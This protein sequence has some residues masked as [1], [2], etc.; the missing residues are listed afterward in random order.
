MIAKCKDGDFWDNFFSDYEIV[1]FKVFFDNVFLPYTITTHL[2]FDYQLSLW[3]STT[4]LVNK[5]RCNKNIELLGCM[6]NCEWK[7]IY[8]F[9]KEAEKLFNQKWFFG[10]M[11][12]EQIIQRL[13]NR[14]KGTFVVRTSSEPG[15][16]AISLNKG[17]N[18]FMHILLYY[19]KQKQCFEINDHGKIINTLECN[20]NDQDFSKILDGTLKNPCPGSDY[21]CE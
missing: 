13:Y 20:L 14:D 10:H 11:S 17:N 4:G 9:L 2:N 12:R 21:F 3:F 1:M 5:Q 6:I 18:S 19:N 7:N 8:K 16:L 15:C